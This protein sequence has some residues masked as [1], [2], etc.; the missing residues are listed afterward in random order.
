ME[1]SVYGYFRFIAN[2]ENKIVYFEEF[3]GHSKNGDDYLDND[4]DFNSLFNMLCKC[5]G[6][7][8]Q[9]SPTTY[10]EFNQS[11]LWKD[12]EFEIN[13]DFKVGSIY[14]YVHVEHKKSFGQFAEEWISL[15][16]LFVAI[17]E[18]F[19]F[20]NLVD[21]L[22]FDWGTNFRYGGYPEK[23][24]DVL[25]NLITVFKLSVDSEMCLKDNW[26]HI[27]NLYFEIFQVENN[28]GELVTI[29]KRELENLY[30]CIRDKYYLG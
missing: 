23:G 25:N 11:E 6:K 20:S 3:E 30:K 29:D 14:K 21:N 10:E 13:D 15:P 24:L 19:R 2:E 16:N 12:L 18:E 7:T 26:E 4:L 27:F 5:L 8:Y 22:I 28:Y 9:V 17:S 1:I